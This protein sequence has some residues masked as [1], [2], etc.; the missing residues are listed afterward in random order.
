M[1]GNS[2]RTRKYFGIAAEPPL[3]VCPRPAY[4]EITKCQ[5]QQCTEAWMNQKTTGDDAAFTPTKWK[6]LVS[7]I[8]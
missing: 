4:S 1:K 5:T 6:L 3:A 7:A 2:E 8:R